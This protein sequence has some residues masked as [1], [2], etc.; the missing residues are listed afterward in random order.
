MIPTILTSNLHIEIPSWF[1]ARYAKN[2]NFYGTSQHF[3][4][5]FATPKET[6][7]AYVKLGTTFPISSKTNWIPPLSFLKDLQKILIDDTT[8]DN[9]VLY[10]IFL[11]NNGQVI[12]FTITKE[13]VN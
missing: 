3:N 2:L 12:K 4:L 9:P 7:D 8:Q 10:V 1:I 6:R 5:D 13:L 11:H